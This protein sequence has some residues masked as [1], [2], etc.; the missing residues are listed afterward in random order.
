LRVRFKSDEKFRQICDLLEI[1]DPALREMPFKAKRDFLGF[2]EE[3]ALMVNTGLMR[4]NV[5]H[6]MFGYYALR[7]SNSKNFWSDVNRES[8]YWAVFFHFVKQMEAIEE[9]FKFDYRKCGLSRR[10]NRVTQDER[11]ATLMGH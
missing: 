6:H 9:S 2:F 10:G 7:S 5:A 8:Y 1:D 3:I 4:K 11:C